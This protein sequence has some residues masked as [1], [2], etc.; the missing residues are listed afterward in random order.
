MCGRFVASRPV[1]EI[2]QLLEVDEVDVPPE[3]SLPR[4]NVAPQATVL[5][6][7]EPRNEPGHRR[8]SAF[9]WGLVPWWAKDPSI[10]GRAFNAKA[11]T[12]RDKPMFRGAI[13]KQRCI[14]PADAFYEWAPASRSD[15]V[16]RK[17][18]WCFRAPGSG[19]LLLG[20][21]W[22]QWRPRHDQ[23]APP[24]RTCTILTTDANDV[25]GHVHDRMPVLI[26]EADLEEWLSPDPLSSGE[27]G[28]LI[29]PAPPSALE[30][31]RVSTQVND[32]RREGPEL[33]ER[34]AEGPGGR[35]EP[36]GESGSERPGHEQPG[37]EQPGHE[38]PAAH[39]EPD[40]DPPDD[41]EGSGFAQRF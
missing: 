41:G 10:G 38:R 11:E 26:T 18:P 3:L 1:G 21:L 12:V 13:E 27:F 39:A 24:L 20:G 22:E 31:F 15:P 7:T 32:A 5:A 34:L 19:L 37:H 28:R 17:Q 9:R 14:V 30:A 6:V 25:V 36:G 23:S 4:W 40:G 35:A 16:R 29:R 2:A 8:L 33:V